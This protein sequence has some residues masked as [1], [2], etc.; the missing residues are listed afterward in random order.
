M[1]ETKHLIP[2]QPPK[3]AILK[4]CRSAFCQVLQE[5]F[6]CTAQIHN[7]E[8]DSLSPFLTSKASIVSEIKYSKQLARQ[9]KVSV[10]KGDLTNHKVDAVV[11]PAN[12]NLSHGGGLAQALSSAGGH[13][14]QKCSNDIIKHLGKIPTGEVVATP[15][16]DLPCKMII[17]AVGPCVSRS[18]SKAELDSASHLLHN[19]IWNILIKVDYERLE[20]VAIPAISSGLF[21]FPLPKCAE[22]I[23]KALKLY[24]EKRNLAARNLEVRLVNIDDPSVQHME[25]ACLQFLGPSDTKPKQNQGNS[26]TQSSIASL[27]LGNVTLH[28]KKGAIENERTDVIVNTIGADLQLSSGQVSAALLNKAGRRI[29]EEIR[30]LKYG[31][32][33]E[34]DILETS[35][36]NLDC[37][38]VY[39]T[40][41]GS[42]RALAIWCKRAI[43]LYS[44][45][46]NCLEMASSKSYSSMSFPA[47]GTGNLG[48]DKDE[49][50]QIMTD[51]VVE[52]SKNYKG[53]KMLIFFVIFPKDTQTLKAFEKKIISTKGRLERE[54]HQYP[55]TGTVTVFGPLAFSAPGFLT[56]LGSGFQDSQDVT[57]EPCIELFASS[58]TAMR[59]AKR[60]CYDMLHLS[61]SSQCKTIYN[62]H[63]VYLSQ[64][65]HEKL[66]TLQRSLEVIITEFIKEGKGGVIINGDPHGILCAA[67]EV[68]AML[69][70][71]QE[72]FARDEERYMWADL[73]Q[74]FP[75]DEIEMM[76]NRLYKKTAID[77]NMKDPEV[78][79]RVKTFERFGLTI[80][81]MEKIENYALNQL[82]EL[83][84]KRI[85]PY[86]KPLYQRVNAQFCDLICRVGFQREYAPPKEQACGAGIYFTTE[87]DEAFTLWEDNGEEYIYFIEAQVLTGKQT[88]GSTD[89]IVPPPNGTDP[90][91]RYDSVTNKKGIHV[92]FNGQHAY[93][94]RIITCTEK[95]SFI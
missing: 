30:T 64:E 93:P 63:V 9:L 86:H 17:H 92:I 33:S 36:H 42:N 88:S 95:K 46:T 37:K 5:K 87:A 73:E 70:K 72:D 22:V 8:D 26:S 45:V 43:I 56:H 58:K 41:C 66:M 6:G 50:S 10:W 76:S 62:N 31:Y 13:M 35:G 47:L 57:T 25:R 90:L 82:F 48:L 65:D 91:V 89:L 7:V 59:E 81:K 20:S 55:S 71:A 80:E 60:W 3:I 28:L 83:N 69:C 27:N 94:E 39:H 40:V 4:R 77:L 29:Q 21:N 34:G 61:S 78:K 18:P 19:T 11:N 51:A 12:E 1:E 16:G 75:A 85:K 32:I 79:Q 49:V 15:A 53:S 2:L 52:F 23:V 67:L 44:V 38:E 68:E 84:S 54:Q 14:I 24:S 74:M